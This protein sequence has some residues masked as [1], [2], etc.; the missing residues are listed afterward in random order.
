MASSLAAAQVVESVNIVGY[1]TMVVPGQAY[2]TGPT[3]V[4]IGTES[5]KLGDITTAVGMEA[6]TDIIQFLNATT[7]VTEFS[8]TYIDSA[9]S[10]AIAGDES[11]VGWWNL[12]ID[13]PLNDLEFAAGSGFLCNFTSPGITLVYAG[14]VLQGSTTL[15]YS[16]QRSPMI[17]NFTPVDLTLGDI[18][19]TGMEAGTDIIQFLDTTTAVTE[20]TATY[21]DPATS[22]AIAGDESLVGWWNL[23]IDTSLNNT[24]FPAGSAVL[25]NFTSPSVSFTFPSPI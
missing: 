5:W 17:A 15:D 6:G 7:A 4:G 16:G 8:A 3:F 12:D 14:E 11:L 23:D 20:L 10:I 2:S 22:I 25:G 21:I 9:T 1:Q 19:V 24:P 18:I 13:T